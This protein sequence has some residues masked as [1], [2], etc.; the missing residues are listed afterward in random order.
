LIKPHFGQS[1]SIMNLCRI[2]TAFTRRADCKGR[3]V[4][5]NRNAGPVECKVMV[6]WRSFRLFRINELTSMF[7]GRRPHLDFKRPPD[8]GQDRTPI[9]TFTLRKGIGDMIGHVRQ[10]YTPHGGILKRA[11]E[12][13]TDKSIVDQPSAH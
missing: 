6:R 9:R 3:D 13:T 11:W 2:T 4:S 12:Q 1:Q 7:V 8:R 5:E 10:Q